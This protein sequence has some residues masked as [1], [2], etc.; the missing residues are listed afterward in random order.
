MNRLKRFQKKH[1]AKTKSTRGQKRA[2]CS[3][4][5]HVWL[6]TLMKI[7]LSEDVLVVRS[8]VVSYCR[9]NKAANRGCDWRKIHEQQI[10]LT[11][12]AV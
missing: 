3:Q 6:V 5:E 9:L 10:R 2:P 1:R 4:K 8:V 12:W 11:F 7:H